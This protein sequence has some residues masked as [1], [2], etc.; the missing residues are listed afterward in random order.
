MRVCIYVCM[1]VCT[2]VCLCICVYVC[3]HVYYAECLYAQWV[4]VRVHVQQCV[5][6]VPQTVKFLT[7]LFSSHPANTSL[8]RET[9]LLPVMYTHWERWREAQSKRLRQVTIHLCATCPKPYCEQPW[10]SHTCK[11]LWTTTKCRNWIVQNHTL[12]YY[13]KCIL[14]PW[15]LVLSLMGCTSSVVD[16]PYVMGSSCSFVKRN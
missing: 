8:H 11:R 2:F 14:S 4:C 3:T 7:R 6:L 5:M 12:A 9:V 15:K 10:E 13:W 1:C 16:T